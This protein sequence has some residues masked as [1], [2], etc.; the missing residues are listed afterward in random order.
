[1]SNAKTDANNTKV[2]IW[3]SNSDGITPIMIAVDPAD[4]RV[5]LSGL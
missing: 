1:M 3:V 5:L 4:G 2:A